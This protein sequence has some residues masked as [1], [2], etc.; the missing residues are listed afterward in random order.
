MSWQSDI[1]FQRT[2]GGKIKTWQIFVDGDSYCT[3]TG[4]YGKPDTYKVSSN[5]MCHP[6]N[7]GR[8]NERSASIVAV[9]TAKSKVQANLDGGYVKSIEDL[10]AQDKIPR[11]MLARPKIEK[12]VTRIEA[13]ISAGRC[14]V[15]PKL[16]GF[17]CLADRRGLWTRELRPITTCPHI[18][19]ALKPVFD[20]N[21]DLV[22][23]GELY[24]HAYKNDFG[25]LQS[26]LTKQ[27]VDLLDALE[28]EELIQFHVYDFVDRVSFA[29][30]YISGRALVRG[31]E[32]VNTVNTVR[33]KSIDHVYKKHAAF[34]E[35][36]YEGTM[37][38]IS[39]KPYEQNKRASQLVKLKDADDAEFTITDVHEGKGQW[40]GYAKSLT[41]SLPSGDTFD[42][43]CAGTQ[44]Q[45][46]A[47][48]ERAEDYVGGKATVQ[49]YGRF[50]SG[51]PRFPVAVKYF[52]R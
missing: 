33:A 12:E 44:E 7:V 39:D 38:R 1:L 32:H 37:V 6:K 5:T 30:R 20:D 51:K 17:R 23:D 52:T 45:L 2:P 14:Y 28:T 47:V 27:N 41:C 19:K 9:D 18:E 48:L 31:C 36:G 46:R 49:F 4:E 43:G 22:I 10:E 26:I 25:K 21:P 50:P 42:S 13:A 11:A 8:S 15:Q 3:E 16:D 34:K 35:E 40:A 29:L 24:N